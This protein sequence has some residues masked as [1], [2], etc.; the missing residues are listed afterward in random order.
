MKKTS[1]ILV[2][3]L[4]CTL[5]FGS[6]AF[7]SD[8]TAEQTLNITSEEATDGQN[9]TRSEKSALQDF[10]LSTSNRIVA[11]TSESVKTTAGEVLSG[12]QYTY[13]SASEI[14]RLVQLGYAWNQSEGPISITKGT[15]NSNNWL[16]TTK[17]VYLVCLS[18][19]DFVAQGQTTGVIT[20]LLSGFDL[21]NRYAQNVKKVITRNIPAGSNIIV[22]GHSLGGMVAQQIVADRNIKAS[23]NV[24]NTVTFGS[25]L[26]SALRREGTVKRLGDTSDVVP[27]LSVN[28]FTN[29]LW[30]ALGLQRE[31]GRYTDPLT[32]HCNSYNRDDVW[33]AYDVTGDKYGKKTITLD[34]STIAFFYSP[35]TVTD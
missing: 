23:Y 19:T 29:I 7:A 33:G 9:V 32:A 6:T 20:D 13:A 30:Q 28:T 15:L 27:Y 34:Y 5:L 18:G 17:S 12:G 16:H 25:P 11:S 21:D 24:L 3:T 31:N 10:I 35:V 4:T 2:L 14:S 8:G 26:L 22:T 1:I